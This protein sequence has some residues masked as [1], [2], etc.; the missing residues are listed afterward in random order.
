MLCDDM[1]L[2]KTY[3]AL[4]FCA[5]LGELMDKKEIPRRPVLLIAPVG[6]LRT[7]ENEQVTH[8]MSPGLGNI[9]R[10]YGENL[11]QIKRGP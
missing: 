2:G 7:W 4:A 10:A 8:L 1:G 3:Q 5:W 6:L 11:K 9:L